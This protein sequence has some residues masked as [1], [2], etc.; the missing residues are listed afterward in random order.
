MKTKAQA[1]QT[2]G[3][4]LIVLLL[5]GVLIYFV[6][7]YIAKPGT[8]LGAQIE[9]YKDPGCKLKGQQL[10]ARG[11]DFADE[12][13][14]L[15]PDLD[16][17]VCVGSDGKGHNDKDNDA[18]GVPD[19]CDADS[20]DAQIGFCTAKDCTDGKCKSSKACEKDSTCGKDGK[21]II[22]ER[23]KGEFYCTIS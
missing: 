14:D 15:R 3:K 9:L 16:C 7:N 20:K 17:D 21:G 12:D 23:E 2:V 8:Q 11:I 5:M 10:K 13:N 1:P 4:L 22:K 6:I 18:D 19:D